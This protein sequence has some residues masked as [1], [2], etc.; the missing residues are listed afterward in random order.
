MQTTE[1]HITEPARELLVREGYDVIVAGGGI[2]GVAAAVAAARNGAS[3]ILLERTCALGGLATLGNVIMW[4]PLCDGRGRQVIGGLPEELLKLSVADLRQ[5][6]ESA[7]FIGIPSCWQPGGDPEQR[8]QIRYQTEFNPAAYLLAL[9]KLIVDAGVKLLYDTRVCAVRRESNRISHVIVENKSGRSA[10]ACRMAVDATGD[11]DVCFLAGE[12]TEALDSNVLAGWFYYLL[13][14]S[15]HLSMLSNIP[16]FDGTKTGA[17]GPFFGGDQAE[18][19]TAHIVGTRDLIRRR[20]A[21]IRAEHPHADPQAILLPTIPCFRMT[22]RLV[23]AFSLGERHCHQWF[24]DAVGLTGDWR[25]SGPVYAI[26]WRALC[27]VN[28]RNLLTAGRC[29][30]ADTTIWDAT[31]AIPACALT[32]AAVGVAAA[33]AVQ[34]SEGNAH[35]LSVTELQSR[36]KEQGFIL[37]PS[38][39]KPLVEDTAKDLP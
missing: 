34:R 30:S 23:G 26:P 14:N 20:L 19:V 1:S 37:D 36:L 21:E 28:N 33:L 10:L 16:S 32:G 38:S 18:D 8:K 39:V 24:D 35:S 4:L 31:R 2:A 5:N 15:L 6:N 9:E 3:V 13:E 27:A 29:I 7:C 12:K 22:R 17:Q 25:R 11:A